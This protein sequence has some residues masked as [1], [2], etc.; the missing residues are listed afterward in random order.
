MVIYPRD[1]QT[2]ILK[3]QAF[4]EHLEKNPGVFAGVSWASYVSGLGS[5][6]NIKLDVNNI[7]QPILGNREYMCIYTVYIYISMMIAIRCKYICIHIY[8]YKG[9]MHN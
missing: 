1:P 4:P 9:S 8:I 7:E 5:L 2:Q 3:S 6:M